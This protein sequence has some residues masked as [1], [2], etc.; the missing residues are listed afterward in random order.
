MILLTVFVYVTVGLLG[1]LLMAGYI[2]RWMN[3]HRSDPSVLEFLVFIAG[4]IA[5]LCLYI[6]LMTQVF[7]WVGWV[8]A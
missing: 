1:F 7:V 5:L 8:S 6:G 4:G 2:E 3:T